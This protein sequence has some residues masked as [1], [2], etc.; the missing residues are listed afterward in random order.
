M[1]QIPDAEFYARLERD[2]DEID[3]E[4]PSKQPSADDALSAIDGRIVKR[5]FRP[6]LRQLKDRI[7]PI[8]TA[9]RDRE[10]EFLLG[11]GLEVAPDEDA[12]S[13]S[14]ASSDDD[15]DEFGRMR[16]RRGCRRE[17]GDNVRNVD[18]YEETRRFLA[19]KDQM[20]L[21]SMPDGVGLM[22]LPLP[23]RIIEEDI[24]E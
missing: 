22:G 23:R 15:L 2:D 5:H 12:Y 17:D 10:R 9:M 16:K 8:N 4:S 24:L 7:E 20:N 13:S 14:P 1:E 21:L 3:N 18:T 6:V 11:K 19:A